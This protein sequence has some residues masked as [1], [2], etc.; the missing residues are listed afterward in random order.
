MSCDGS[1][2]CQRARRPGTR[3]WSILRLHPLAS[4]QL[5]ERKL[6]LQSLLDRARKRNRVQATDRPS[7]QKCALLKLVL[8]WPES[9]NRRRICLRISNLQTVY[10]NTQLLRQILD[11]I[12]LKSHPEDMRVSCGHLRCRR[13]LML[14][15]TSHLRWLPLIRKNTSS[16]WKP[17]ANPAGMRMHMPLPNVL[18]IVIRRS[19]PQTHAVGPQKYH[20]TQ[21]IICMVQW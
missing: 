16:P 20:W 17:A 8:V 1:L 11:K 21:I 2:D 15:W 13:T 7:I 19:G 18:V 14:S 6:N 9:R 3:R 10:K 5:G 12:A 4:D